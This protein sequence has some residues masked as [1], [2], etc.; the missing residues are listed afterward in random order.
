MEE[1]SVTT[2]QIVITRRPDGVL[3]IIEMGLNA[4]GF[5]ETLKRHELK[6]E[7]SVEMA[8]KYL[9]DVLKTLVPE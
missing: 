2:Q 3:N 5:G 6:P 1:G 9:V 7:I 8:T 4:K